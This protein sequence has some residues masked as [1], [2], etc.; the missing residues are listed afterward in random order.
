MNPLS[1]LTG[2]GGVSASTSSGVGPSSSNSDMSGSFS[3]G[4]FNVGGGLGSM[5]W[6]NL[7][8]IGVVVIVG[9]MAW[10]KIKKA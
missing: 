3:T 6:K 7:A 9:L 5:N 8:I 2:G 4:D 10:T 1:S